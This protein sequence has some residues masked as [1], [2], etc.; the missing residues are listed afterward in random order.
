M[1]GLVGIKNPL[2]NGVKRVVKDCQRAGI[3]FKLLTGDNILT[4]RVM[5]SRSG[6]LVAPDNQLGEIIQGEEFRNYSSEERM[7]KLDNIRV[8]AGANPFDKF[9][10]VQSLKKKGRVV[11]YIGRGMGDVQAIREAD[12]GLCFGT[13][14]GAEILK[15]CSAI[16][17]QTKDFPLVI[18]ILRWGRGF[19]D[20]IQTYTQFL[21]TATLVDLVVDF[22]MSIFPSDPPDFD[23]VAVISSGKIPYPVFQLLW[24]KL[25][26][27]FFAALSLIIKQPSEKLMSKPPRDR[28]K[29]LMNDIVLKNISAQA[30]YQIAVLL[31]I[32]FKGKSILKVDVN[33]KNTLIFNTY[34]LCQVFTVINARLFEEKKVFQEMHNKKCFWGIIGL[35]VLLQVMLVDVLMSLAGTARLDSR[36]WGICILIAAASTPISWLLKYITALRKIPFLKKSKT[37]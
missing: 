4:A 24:V 11:A 21:I 35:I 6:I 25:I 15:A 3:N 36:K 13:Q 20:S 5:A 22:V 29:P 26:L 14:G 37:E 9:L 28:N 33:E 7:E 16:V 8:L 2:R 32:H 27:G 18:D 23:A 12:V 19:Y 17:T 34:V 10:M 31:T 30:I 1:L